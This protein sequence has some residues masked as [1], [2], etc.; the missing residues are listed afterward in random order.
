MAKAPPFVAA[1][2]GPAGKAAVGKTSKGNPFAAAKGNPFAKARRCQEEWQEGPARFPRLRAIRSISMAKN[3]SL[4]I[5]K[6]P[7]VPAG[8][9][10]GQI[11]KTTT[12]PKAPQPKK[13]STTYSERSTRTAGPK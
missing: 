3:G 5:K 1:K 12:M 4:P 10:M 7:S 11:A 9:R 2:K 13:G 8:G 6:T